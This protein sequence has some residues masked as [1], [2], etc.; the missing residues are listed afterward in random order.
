MIERRDP[1]INMNQ[2]RDTIMNPMRRIEDQEVLLEQETRFQRKFVLLNMMVLILL[3]LSVVMGWFVYQQHVSLLGMRATLSQVQGTIE[4][5]QLTSSIFDD[6][7]QS[8]I[9][10]LNLQLEKSQHTIQAQLTELTQLLADIKRNNLAAD[11]QFTLIANE[12][13]R[14]DTRILE[15]QDQYD[16][17]N[18]TVP[19][20]AD[21]LL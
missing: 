20:N 2:V 15:L 4:P 13:Q 9:I 12:F 21:P 18:E 1:S 14:I 19:L 6:T 10:T 16:G 3:L 17:L 5:M 8:E 7:L 11:A